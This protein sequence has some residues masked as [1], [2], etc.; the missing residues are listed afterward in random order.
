[1]SINF[2][3]L[4]L[5][6]GCGGLSEGFIET[7]FNPVSF[8]EMNKYACETLKYRLIYHELKK[9]NKLHIY[10][11]L[12]KQEI[13]LNY[14]FIKYPEIE[15][16]LELKIINKEIE[17]NNL[18]IIIKLIKRSQKYNNIKKINVLLGGPPCQAYSLI[19]RASNSKKIHEDHRSY[20]YQYYLDILKIFQ[21]DFF[22]FENVPGLLSAKIDGENLLQLIINDFHKIKPQYCIVSNEFGENSDFKNYILNA[23]EFSI[24]QNRSRIILI[25][26]KRSLLKTNP[27]IK[28][29]FKLL[30]KNY[31]KNKL[32][33]YDA[34]GDLP[35]LK[36]G[37]G[38]DYWLCDY[39]YRKI[40][41]SYQK[42][43]RK[44]STGIY[45]HKARTHMTKDLLRYRY[46]IESINK[47][48]KQINLN[49][50]KKNRP[51]L[52]PEHNTLDK[53]HDRFKV[54]KWNLPSSTIMAHISKDGHYYIH[55]DIEQTRSFTVREAARCQSFP[56]NY[57][58]AGPRTEQFK[59]VGNAVPPRLSKYIA[60]ILLHELK[61]I[62]F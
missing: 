1:M 4:D 56:D 11:K 46:Y 62:Y 48:M 50:L 51:D 25:G 18:D 35:K 54:Q 55:P 38:N 32:T 61:T 13:G 36:P 20:L 28:N 9:K 45:N 24:P 23:A 15:K 37:E 12:L 49:Y 41:N 44:L 16:Q 3:F 33:V 34:I 19:G 43:M 59:Q 30:K 57:F 6:A 14:I 58:F 39:E 60:K 47:D 29:I 10:F 40:D 26:Y 42:E 17:Y 22:V 31:N 7:G 2:T 52:L 5:F 27:N 21:P 8:L 53:F